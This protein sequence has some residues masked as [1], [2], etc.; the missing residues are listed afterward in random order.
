MQAVYYRD[1]HGNEPV[2]D[3]IDQLPPARQVE[4]DATIALLNRLK[5]TDPPLPFPYSSQ[6]EG[7]L[8]ELRCH[9]GSDLYRILYRRSGN[10]FILL[11]I[12]RK[13]TEKVPEAD[14]WIAEEYWADFKS[15]MDAVPRHPPRAAGHDA[16]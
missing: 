2:N 11:H 5:P 10:L 15:R 14:K 7:P 3:Y 6:V 4:V 8:R 12:F 16:P 1:R 9:Y 13:H